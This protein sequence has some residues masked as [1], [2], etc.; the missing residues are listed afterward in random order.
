MNQQNSLVDINAWDMMPVG[1]TAPNV[2]MCGEISFDD[3]K[4]KLG[5]EE[6]G[7]YLYLVT[8]LPHPDN[9]KLCIVFRY[10][11]LKAVAAFCDK[12]N[13]NPEDLSNDNTLH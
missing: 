2:I 13:E 3:V 7:V 8:D 4:W 10:N 12:L 9:S 5:R 6:N 11:P 1:W